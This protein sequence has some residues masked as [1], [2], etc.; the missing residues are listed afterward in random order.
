MYQLS[1]DHQGRSVTTTDHPDRDDAHRSPHQLRHRR[2]LLPA[3]AAHAPDTTRYELLALAEPDSRAT[4]PHHTGHAT[5]APAGR[6]PARPPPTTP[7]SPRSDGSPTT[8]TPGTTEPT[9]TLSALPAGG[10]HRR[11]R[12]RALLVHRW[13]TLARSRTTGWSRAAHRTRSA[14]PGDTA[15]PRPEPGRYPPQ[16]RRAGR[17]RARRFAHRH[18]HRPSQRP[19]LVVCPA[20]LGATAS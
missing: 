1:I 2:R 19:D 12:R 5:I 16:P 7:P 6:K 8:T 20:D 9:P 10:P 17:R 4:R 3:A 15:P 11:P 18:H 14:C 13:H